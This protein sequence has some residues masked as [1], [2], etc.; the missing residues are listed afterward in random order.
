MFQAMVPANHWFAAE[1][2][3]S[4]SEDFSLLGCT[5]APGFEFSEFE[6]A[7]ASD[8][9]DRFPAHSAIIHGLARRT[10]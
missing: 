9:A 5:V 7:E 1:R 3:S 2:V 8:L 4:G 10:A 6:L